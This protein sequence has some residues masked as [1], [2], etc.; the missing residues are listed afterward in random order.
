MHCALAH[1]HTCSG[2]SAC[3][4]SYVSNLRQLSLWFKQR[5]LTDVSNTCKP[6]EASPICKSSRSLLRDSRVYEPVVES[7]SR[8]WDVFIHPLGTYSDAQRKMCCWF[9]IAVPQVKPLICTRLVRIPLPRFRVH[10]SNPLNRTQGRL[11]VS[12]IPGSWLLAKS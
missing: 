5:R 6:S 9:C 1:F 8:R 4:D 7:I 11:H 3:T 12:A 10:D 2:M